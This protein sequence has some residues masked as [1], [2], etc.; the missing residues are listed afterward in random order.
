MIRLFLLIAALLIP[1]AVPASDN[2]NTWLLVETEQRRL[3]VY[4]GDTPVLE[5]SQ[6]ALGRGGAAPDR[7]RGD[8][9]TPKGEFRIAWVNHE[10][11]Y[12]IFL[13][14]D[15]PTFQHARRA[16]AA[17]RITLDEFLAVT[18]AIR[19]GRLP[20]QRTQLGGHIGLHGLGAADPD[21]HRIADW[22]QGCIAMTDEE[23]EQLAN[24]VG[25]GTRVVVR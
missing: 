22:T 9:R 20:P 4:Q 17:G 23:I 8:R 14:L 5:I 19:A 15:Y 12:H 11:Q 7:L 18:D 10:S 2:G 3:H 24:L 6:V 21:I 16:Y 13:G 1:Y 25:I